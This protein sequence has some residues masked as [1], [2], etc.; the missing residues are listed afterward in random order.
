M[1]FA[2]PENEY[3]SDIFETYDDIPEVIE[4]TLIN[5]LKKIGK[6]VLSVIPKDSTGLPFLLRIDFGCCLDNKKV[7]RDYFVNEIEYVPN[8]FPE[9]SIHIDIL[10]NPCPP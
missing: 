3:D 5:R 6:Q 1:K 10:K 2:Y 9:Y 8:L 4:Q 7:C